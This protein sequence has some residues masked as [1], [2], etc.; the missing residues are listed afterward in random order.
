MVVNIV[1]GLHKNG[2]NNIDIDYIIQKL[3]LLT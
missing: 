3:T 1:I 2:K